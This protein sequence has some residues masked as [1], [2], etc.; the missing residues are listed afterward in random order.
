MVCDDGDVVQSDST[1]VCIQGLDDSRIGSDASDEVSSGSG[2]R[3]DWYEGRH[4]MQQCF[5]VRLTRVG[6]KS[7]NKRIM[8]DTRIINRR[9]YMMSIMMLMLLLMKVMMKV[10]RLRSCRIRSKSY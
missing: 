4:E 1:D 7:S 3:L 10:G 8:L 9:R 2:A 5:N 6:I